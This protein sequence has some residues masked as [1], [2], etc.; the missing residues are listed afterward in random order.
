VLELSTT[1]GS[2]LVLSLDSS[3]AGE[4]AGVFS[5]CPS[6]LGLRKKDA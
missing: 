5:T 3:I 6:L 2:F 4:V 1:T